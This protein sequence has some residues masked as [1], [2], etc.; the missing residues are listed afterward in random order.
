[1]NAILQVKRV[2]AAK[3]PTADDYVNPYTP[4]MTYSEG[5]DFHWPFFEPINLVDEQGSVLVLP[6][7]LT[8]P[9]FGREELNQRLQE[10]ATS[11]PSIE[12]VWEIT[13]R[14]PSLSKLLS[15]ERDNE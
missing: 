12:Q 13:K 14:L 15:E 6:Q 3:N 4:T 11:A 8:N 7:R 9:L 10:M 5:W 1:M 2:S